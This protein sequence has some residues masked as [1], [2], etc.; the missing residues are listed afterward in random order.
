MYAYIELF[1]SICRT[2]VQNGTFN[3]NAFGSIESCVR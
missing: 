1:V 3:C 2:F